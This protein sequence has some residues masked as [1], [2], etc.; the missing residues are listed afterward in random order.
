MSELYQRDITVF[1]VAKQAGIPVVVN[2]AGGYADDYE[3]TLQIHMNTGEALK[4]VY[5]GR[6]CATIPVDVVQQEEA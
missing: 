2:L 1:S 4:E 3:H 5:L 6:G